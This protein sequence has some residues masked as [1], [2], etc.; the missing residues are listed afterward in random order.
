MRSDVRLRMSFQRYFDEKKNS[1]K[2]SRISIH[3]NMDMSFSRMIQSYLLTSLKRV[4]RNERTVGQMIP[5]IGTISESTISIIF[6]LKSTEYPL[7]CHSWASLLFDLNA[8][9][10]CF[11]CTVDVELISSFQTDVRPVYSILSVTL[12]SL[13]ESSSSYALFSVTKRSSD[14][15]RRQLWKSLVSL[16]CL[17]RWSSWYSYMIECHSLGIILWI[18]RRHKFSQLELFRIELVFSSFRRRPYQSKGETHTCRNESIVTYLCSELLRK[19]I[20]SLQNI[21]VISVQS[22]KLSLHFRE[23]QRP[24]YKSI[25][26]RVTKLL[27]FFSPILHLLMKTDQL[28][29]RLAKT[30]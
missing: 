28:S 2:L 1:T 17:H 7:W 27:Q 22:Y 29:F 11:Y 23:S 15:V 8:W 3:G 21:E 13:L 12:Q 19:E 25:S 9:S 16:C 18:I 30:N 14:S 4:A 6:I 20:R 26:T 5:F 10:S 24:Q